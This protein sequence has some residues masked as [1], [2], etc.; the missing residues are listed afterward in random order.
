MDDD[1]SKIWSLY[2][3][4]PR[5]IRCPLI[6]LPPVSGTADVFFRQILALTGWGYRVIAVSIIDSALQFKPA[7]RGRVFLFYFV[8]CMRVFLFLINYSK[9]LF[10]FFL[11]EVRLFSLLKMRNEAFGRKA[12]QYTDVQRC[13]GGKLLSKPPCPAFMYILLSLNGRK[14]CPCL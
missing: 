14:H 13:R 4:G 6:F 10:F 1:D 2:D 7:F 3:A 12:V 8:F 11:V 9:G 5:N